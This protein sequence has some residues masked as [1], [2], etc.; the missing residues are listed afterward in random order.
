MFIV[1]VLLLLL[2]KLLQV[3][4]VFF[5]VKFVYRGGLIE[6]KSE[7]D[8]QWGMKMTTIWIAQVGSLVYSQD[9]KVVCII[10]VYLTQVKIV[11]FPVRNESS[12]M[13]HE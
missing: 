6:R 9:Y 3:C 13:F 12:N 11:F 5:I 7:G 1:I 2:N 4:M 10:A 8:W